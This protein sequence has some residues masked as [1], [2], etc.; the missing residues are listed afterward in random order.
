MREIDLSVVAT[1][2]AAALIWTNSEE[3][4]DAEPDDLGDEVKAA[5]REDSDAFV[6][7]CVEHR[8]DVFDDMEDAQIG[9]NFAL[10]RNHEGAGFW[11]RG[12]GEVGQWLT[13]MAHPYGEA[14]LYVG[15]DGEIYYQS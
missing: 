15:D 9:H 5:I 7:G 6:N 10:T 13:E 3:I 14:S 4:G 2:Y 8:P 11:D 12:L 1:A